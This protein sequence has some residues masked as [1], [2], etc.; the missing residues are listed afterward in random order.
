[1]FLEIFYN[2]IV[3]SIFNYAVKGNHFYQDFKTISIHLI[4]LM[5]LCK[6]HPKIPDLFNRMET[7]IKD[8][9]YKKHHQYLQKTISL[10]S[11]RNLD[12]VS[13]PYP[14]IY[15][16]LCL[17]VGVF[18]ISL[19][20][21]II[22]FICQRIRSVNSV[23]NRIFFIMNI[24]VFFF[25]L[26]ILVNY[27]LNKIRKKNLYF[28]ILQKKYKEYKE[29]SKKNEKINSNLFSPN[30]NLIKYFKEDGN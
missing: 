27:L 6:Y 3:I 29:E 30:S 2:F 25:F 24:L 5:V 14:K 13:M 18:Q 4:N 20:T 8:K 17:C 7:I 26:Q 23:S 15:F 9:R 21:L 12:I 28:K 19:G 16:K 22:V 10:I 1:M 11:D